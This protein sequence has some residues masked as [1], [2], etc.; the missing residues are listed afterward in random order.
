[1]RCP[2][3]PRLSG[4]KRWP[5]LHIAFPTRR[6]GRGISYEVLRTESRL[7]SWGIPSDLRGSE[8]PVLSRAA[9]GGLADDTRVQTN[10]E[11]PGRQTE[12]KAERGC[13]SALRPRFAS[14]AKLLAFSSN[15]SG[16]LGNEA[17]AKRGPGR[18]SREATDQG[19]APRTGARASLELHPAG[20]QRGGPTCGLLLPSPAH[21]GGVW[22]RATARRQQIG[23][24][25]CSRYRWAE[26][27]EGSGTRL[28]S[29]QGEMSS[30]IAFSRNARSQ[31]VPDGHQ[32]AASL[33]TLRRRASWD[34]IRAPLWRVR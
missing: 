3:W 19:R 21:W 23:V 13:P 10:R 8:T 24:A 15:E 20:P 9:A 22:F 32:T 30:T 25:C 33:E 16:C 5:F 26:G 11:T 27:R 17:R 12:G 2:C 28:R 1:M 34:P 29:R 14:T 18:Q 4:T 6:V 31:P 7:P